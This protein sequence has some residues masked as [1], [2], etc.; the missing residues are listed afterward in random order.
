MKVLQVITSL[1]TGGAEKLITDMA[2]IYKQQGVDVDVL[3]FDGIETAFKRQLEGQ[4]INIIE[5]GRN[6]S[7]YNPMHIIRLI[8]H[9]RSHTYDWVHT[10]NTAC[11]LFAAIASL[12]APPKTRFCTTEHNTSNRRRQSTLLKHLDRWMYSRYSIVFAVSQA[13]ASNLKSHVTIS[14]P[15]IT[16][17]NGISIKRYAEAQAVKKD[18]LGCSANTFLIVMVAAFRPQKDQD[19]AIRA[20]LH[21]PAHTML[22]LVGDGVR[23]AECEQLA[24]QLDLSDRIIFTGVRPDVPNILKAADAVVMS[25]HYEGFGL[26]AVEGMAAGKPVIASD[27]PG[28]ADIVRDYGMLFPKEDDEALAKA[29]T[30]LISD[31]SL[32]ASIAERCVRR[33]SAYDL[34][35]TSQAYID[36]YKAYKPQ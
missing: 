12:F 2:P 9:L 29:I 22:C 8:R 10:H 26:A 27:V 3:L 35:K 24:K 17:P 36:T 6:K 1:R 7:V 14:C 19:T 18:S 34:R 4:K 31:S 15:V 16:I 20:M 30:Q 28:L 32:Y 21:L 25:S 5:F 23:R 11:Q 13:T 33:A